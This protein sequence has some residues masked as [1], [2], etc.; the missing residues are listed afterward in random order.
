HAHLYSA[1]HGARFRQ[2]GVRLV[3]IAPGPF[4]YSGLATG[5]L[6]GFYPPEQD[7][8]DMATLMRAAAGEFVQGKAAR[9]D[10]DARRIVLEDGREIAYDALSINVGSGAIPLPGADMAANVYPLKPLECLARLRRDLE[11]AGPDPRRLVVVGG[12]TSGSEIAM[13]LRA[14]LDRLG[15]KQSEVR[16]LTAGNRLFE[17]FTPAAARKAAGVLAARGVNVSLR[18]R[19]TRVGD[20]VVTT[21]T[22][23]QFA[24]D[25]LVN[26]AG[27][28]PPPL[29]R[30]SGL[31]TDASG[32]LQVNRYLQALDQPGVFG[33]GDCVAFEERPLAKIGVYAVREAP[34]LCHNLLATL[35]C[36][37]KPALRPFK[38]QHHFLQILN[39]GDGTAFAVRR[40][41]FWH[42]RAAFWLKDFLDRRF[43]AASGQGG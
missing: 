8:I 43:L 2:Q 38:P 33:G 17:Q 1:R 35:K 36:D 26:A 18:A 22:G 14:L 13:N 40:G 30:A 24:F 28:Q 11:A 23:E 32:A 31:A 5:M 25:F 19:V 20:S 7:Q 15:A 29:L 27:V 12:G 6:G 21:E 41:L 34:I 42:G 37:G 39:V 9:I 16:L 10:P 3:L 4:W